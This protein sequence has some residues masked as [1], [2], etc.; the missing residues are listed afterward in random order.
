M[1]SGNT[2]IAMELAQFT[3]ATRYEDIPPQVV[4]FTKGLTLKTV[5]A[6]LAGSALPQ[7]RKVTSIVRERRL[8]Q[9]VGIIGSG[10]KTSRWESVFLN[11]YVAHN[12]ELEDDRFAVSGSDEGVSW[13]VTVIPLLLSLAQDLRLSG[14]ALMEALAVGLEVHSRTCLFPVVQLGWAIFP[15]AIGPAAAAARAL[16]LGVEETAAAMGHALQGHSTTRLN[17][18]TDSHYFESALQ[19]LQGMMAAD[20]AQVGMGSNPDLAT[21]LTGVLGK[22]KVVPEK[23]VQDLGTR[24]LFADIAIK[25]YPVCFMQHRQIDLLLEMMNKHGL[26]YDQVETVEVHAAPNDEPCN[27]PEPKAL[28]DLQFSFYHTLGAAMLD[29][30]VDFRHTGSLAIAN[31]PRYKEARSKVKFIMHPDRST[32]VWKAPACLTIKTKDGREFSGERYATIGSPKEPLTM[33]QFR[34]LYAKFSRGVLSEDQIRHTADAILNL[35]KLND[36]EDLMEVLTFRRKVGS[37]SSP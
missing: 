22:D 17:L 8:P 32:V 2:A 29:G 14:K 7:S 11:S 16:G 31:D 24:W 30:D 4:E 9:D 3:V 23:M 5:A 26:K 10:F 19:A 21:Y 37:V 1:K 33:E 13:D 6:A 35:E 18:G 34:A 28:T 12:S 15:G 36:I 27:R 25:K 20:M